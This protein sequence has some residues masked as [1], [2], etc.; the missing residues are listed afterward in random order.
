MRIKTYVFD[1]VKR[2]I[3]VLKKEY[4]P[5]TVILDI[6]ENIKG[7]GNDKLCEISIAIEDLEKN[8]NDLNNS[9]K[10]RENTWSNLMGTT[11]EKIGQLESELIK[12]RLKMFPLP[13][14]SFY[15]KMLKNGFHASMAMN[16]ISEIFQE[17]GE[18]SE[19]TSKVSYFIK[20]KL[21]QKIKVSNISDIDSHIVILGPPG[22]G[23]TQT[24]KKL[25]VML[26]ALGKPVS[27][28]L[29]KFRE[30]SVSENE[31]KVIN[32]ISVD[33]KE[34]LYH[35]V[36]KDDTK[37]II[38]VP[39]KVEIQK[40]IVDRLKDAKSIAVFSAGSRDEKIKRYL[41]IYDSENMMGLIFTR[42]DEEETLGHL[43]SNIIFFNQK[44]CCFTTGRGL[45][46]I[47]MPGKDLFYKILLEGNR[48]IQEEK[49]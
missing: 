16:I 31:K 4:G 29:Y 8:N 38:D 28:I 47:V 35:I 20:E 19:Q 17:I 9:V 18:L 33:K 49:R 39:G 43:L 26:S 25:G 24:A 44:V 12:D 21:C 48:W 14:R 46:D 1:D 23:K 15:E 45:S 3:E 42:L 6:K 2:G 41:D 13:L 22:A 32:V 10:K 27:V 11:I 7:I 34:S 37:K 5:D 30:E 40:E 36:E